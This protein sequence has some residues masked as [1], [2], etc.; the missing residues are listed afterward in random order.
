MVAIFREVRRVLRDDGT[1]WLNLG[2]SYTG[3]GM[4]GGINSLEGSKKRIDRMFH[5]LRREG[6]R[7]PRGL[8]PKDL[9]GIPWRVA[10]ALQ[11]DGWYLR[12]EIIWHKRDP[13]PESVTDRPTK[14]HEHLFLLAKSERYYYDANAIRESDMGTDHRTMSGRNGLG[15][16]RRT[17]WT[18]AT[19]HYAEAHFATFPEALV[20]P[21]IQAGS[22][23]GDTVMDPFCG[24]GTVGVV[25]LAY[26]RAFWGIELKADYVAMAKRRITSDAPLFNHV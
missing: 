7:M 11:A 12:S 6:S 14:S 22:R 21:C 10:F 13:M 24:S 9:V 20:T 15:R 25:A 26:G 8:K 5:G 19:Q 18:I 3:S 1:L 2:D 16:N 4:T 17:V 23:P